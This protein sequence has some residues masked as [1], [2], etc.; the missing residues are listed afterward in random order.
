M[1]SWIFMHLNSTHFLVEKNTFHYQS[2]AWICHF[3]RHF[4]VETLQQP[5]NTKIINFCFQQKLYF[6][7]KKSWN[8]DES[9]FKWMDIYRVWYISLQSLKSVF[10]VDTLYFMKKDNENELTI[11]CF[12]ENHILV[13]FVSRKSLL[14]KIIEG[15]KRSLSRVDGWLPG[16]DHSVDLICHWSRC[17]MTQCKLIK[18]LLN[19]HCWLL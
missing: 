3:H 9:E 10:F 4:L 1:R 18:Q 2:F 8:A 7:E 12:H 6:G 17:I 11:F 15:R 14:C 13:Y 16:W 19:T 5:W